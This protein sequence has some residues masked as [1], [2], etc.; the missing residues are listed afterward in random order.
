M[1]FGGTIVNDVF[2][3]YFVMNFTNDIHIYTIE[4]CV[5]NVVGK[6]IKVSKLCKT[7]YKIYNG[8][9]KLPFLDCLLKRE[10]DG[11]LTSTV[12]RKPTHTD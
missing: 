1:L 12:Y 6:N 5:I 9:R 8:I 10:S 11:M 2:F 7:F 4:I 3:L